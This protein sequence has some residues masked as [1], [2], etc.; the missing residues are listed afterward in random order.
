M[1]PDDAAERDAGAP[2]GRE[3]LAGAEAR[4]PR[5]APGLL[6]LLAEGVDDGVG[7]H[8]DRERGIPLVPTAGQPTL[9]GEAVA[10]EPAGGAF[11]QPGEGPFKLAAGGASELDAFGDAFLG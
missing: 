6:P 3:A 10:V 11:V 8:A 9:R 5:P 2:V 7:A 4:Q 1:S